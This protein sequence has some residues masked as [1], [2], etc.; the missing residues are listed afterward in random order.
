MLSNALQDTEILLYTSKL[1]LSAIFYLFNHQLNLEF[2][3]VMDQLRNI[4]F[5]K[6]CRL[7]RR[8]LPSLSHHIEVFFVVKTL[9]AALLHVYR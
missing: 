7:F 2:Y 1:Q 4:F 6:I 9:E 3:Y 5:I 8:H